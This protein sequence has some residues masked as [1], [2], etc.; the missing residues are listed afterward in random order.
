MTDILSSHFERSFF[1]RQV[2]HIGNSTVVW[3]SGFEVSGDW[4]NLADAFRVIFEYGEMYGTPQLI[5][6]MS[7]NAGGYVN[8]T[9]MMTKFLYPQASFE[10]LMF[11]YETRVSPLMEQ[12][13]SLEGVV[14]DLT[15]KLLQNTTQLEI[16]KSLDSDIRGTI[17]SLK[18]MRNVLKAMLALV[19]GEGQVCGGP[20]QS[21]LCA[22]LR[23]PCSVVEDLQSL[24]NPL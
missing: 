2:T 4:G 24:S 17:S 11:P 9:Y 1:F 16:S 10:E 22:S 20:T 13:I 8:Q 14:G 23:G 3:F 6:D 15:A 7:N 12:A 21:G 5:W 18:K 19:V